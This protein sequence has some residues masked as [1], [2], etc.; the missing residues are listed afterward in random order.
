M[1]AVVQRVTDAKV[2]VEDKI[3]GSIGKG[4]CVL[5]G[6]ETDDTKKDLDYMIEKVSGLRIF[7][8]E[9][10]VM[11]L[12]IL[13]IGGEILSISQF[14]LLGDVRHGKRPSWIRAERP[15]KANEM[16]ELFNEGLRGRGINVE[17]GVF[18]AE[19]LVEINNDGPVTILL[20]S[21][22]LF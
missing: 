13:D 17:E 12:S 16:Y 21:K 8:D 15:E 6:V 4:L 11:N 19:M 22:K 14:T 20:D 5:L 18:Q 10:G 7:D 1:R 2:S 3:C 9:N